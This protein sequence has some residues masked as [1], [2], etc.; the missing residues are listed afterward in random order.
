VKGTWPAVAF[1]ALAALC[2]AVVRDN[3]LLDGLVLILLWG[4]T[5]AA[6]NV[7]GGYA[8]QVSLGH[9]AFFGLGAYAVAILATLLGASAWLGLAAGIVLAAGGAALIGFFCVRASGIPFLMLTLAFSQLVFS[10]ALKWRDVTGGSDGIAIVE[11]PSFLG[12]DLA[13]SVSMYFVALAFFLLSYGGLRRLLNAP[14]GHVF[15]G[16]RENEPRML[17]IGYQTTAYKLLSFTIAGA[18]AGLAGGLY[19]IFN[20]FI[21]PDAIYW[22]SSGD[23]LIMTMLGGAGTLIG[24]AIGAAVFLLMKNVVSSYS[25]HWLAIVGV[26]FICC[27]LFFPG[28]IW[29]TLRQIASPGGK[30]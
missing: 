4:S 12:F 2:A 1:F 28:G 20:S 29:G 21:S 3:F 10:V 22:T 14:L 30:R 23:I 24:P 9:A 27:V 18:F 8:G 15:V 26:T 13:N 19:A 6:W 17:A 25:E 16:I 5:A 7:A 11:K